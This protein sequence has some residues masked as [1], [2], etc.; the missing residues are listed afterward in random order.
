MFNPLTRGRRG[1]CGGLHLRVIDSDVVGTVRCINLIYPAVVNVSN[2]DVGVIE[3]R[4]A[5]RE[6][7]LV[8]S[9]SLER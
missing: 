2:K 3:R 8:M 6:S 5:I 4:H 9:T 7:E 1:A